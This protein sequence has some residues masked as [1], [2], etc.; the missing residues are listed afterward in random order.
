M[1][2]I[3]E[4]IALGRIDEAAEEIKSRIETPKFHVYPYKGGYVNDVNAFFK[5]KGRYHLF[6]QYSSSVEDAPPKV[7]HHSSG[8]DLVHWEYHGEALGATCWCP[9]RAAV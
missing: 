3:E 1:S 2:R 6:Y 4:L 7:W 8:T 5:Y 9:C